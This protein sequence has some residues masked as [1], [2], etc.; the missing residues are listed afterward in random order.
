MDELDCSDIGDIDH[1]N[2]DIVSSWQE[3]IRRGGQIIEIDINM[4][5]D[6]DHHEFNPSSHPNSLT[7]ILGLII[8]EI[9]MSE[10]HLTEVGSSRLGNNSQAIILCNV[11]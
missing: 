9:E 7:R 3:I 1:F 6:Y 11:I 8:G 2:E 10:E 4:D 5:I